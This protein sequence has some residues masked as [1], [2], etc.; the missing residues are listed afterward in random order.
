MNRR[1]TSANGYFTEAGKM[2]HS[3]FWSLGNDIDV[4]YGQ[5]GRTYASQ[6]L[7]LRSVADRRSA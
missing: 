6:L 3:L 7:D 5:D 2:F 4:V 1:K